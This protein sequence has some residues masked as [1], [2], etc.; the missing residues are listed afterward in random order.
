M[1]ISDPQAASTTDETVSYAAT[2]PIVVTTTKD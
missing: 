2:D 1:T